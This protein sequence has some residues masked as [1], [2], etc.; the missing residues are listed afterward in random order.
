VYRVQIRTQLPCLTVKQNC[1]GNY[2][3]AT[4]RQ[5][6]CIISSKLEGVYSYATLDGY[7]KASPA[8]KRAVLET[9]EAL[10]REGHECIEFDVPDGKSSLVSQ[11]EV[12]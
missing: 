11:L 5:V 9:V 1:Q 10:R 4:I 3:L 2:D 12:F 8:C 7:A 6:C